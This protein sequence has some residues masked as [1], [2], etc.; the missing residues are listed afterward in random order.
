L[1]KK[2]LLAFLLAGL[3]SLPVYAAPHS[4]DA[5]AGHGAPP[6]SAPA[7]NAWVDGVVKKIDPAGGKVTV[8]H[9]PLV[10][11]NMS[12]PMTMVF[13]VKDVAWLDRMQVDGRIRFVAESIGGT[14]TIVRF[15]PGK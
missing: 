4:H 11:L 7:E 9:G 8:A 2:S 12:R 10:N 3:A 13:R 6:V 1:I 5:H 15:E 14:L